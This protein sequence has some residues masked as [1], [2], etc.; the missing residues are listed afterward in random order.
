MVVATCRA[1]L[2]GARGGGG[3]RL[4]LDSQ[5]WSIIRVIT[6]HR[7]HRRHLRYLKNAATRYARAA[8]TCR[9]PRVLLRSSHFAAGIRVWHERNRQ[10]VRSGERIS[11]TQ[12]FAGFR[13]LSV[14]K[15]AV[16]IAP[17]QRD[18]ALLFDLRFYRICRHT[19]MKIG[20]QNVYDCVLTWT[21][22]TKAH[23]TLS[24]G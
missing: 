14:H 3:G 5:S 4:S 9:L 2:Q 13:R 21:T 10:N 1:C 7:N 16:S 18:S 6:R 20:E 23:V 15:I 12:P 11:T 8:R 19:W 22:C 24:P 17:I